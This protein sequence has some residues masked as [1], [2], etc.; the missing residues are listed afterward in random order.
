MSSALGYAV[1]THYC[2]ESSASMKMFIDVTFARCPS[3]HLS[4]AA[5][6]SFDK[7]SYRCR[8]PT[9]FT[10][11]PDDL[12]FAPATEPFDQTNAADCR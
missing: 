12:I 7:P 2:T 11:K 5:Q 4:R 3:L 1:K 9:L 8:N 10:F 6:N